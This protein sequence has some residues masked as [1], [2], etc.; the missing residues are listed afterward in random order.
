M[1]DLTILV[2]RVYEW[3][4]H[5][6]RC[7]YDSS[8]RIKSKFGQR[9]STRQIRSHNKQQPV[10]ASCEPFALKRASIIP[11]VHEQQTH[12]T[13]KQTTDTLAH[14]NNP[15]VNKGKRTHLT[16]TNSDCDQDC[17]EWPRLSLVMFFEGPAG[18]RRDGSMDAV[19]KIE[20]FDRI[21]SLPNGPLRGLLGPFG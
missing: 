8:H 20:C 4:K 13:C 16:T 21:S 2:I 1:S 12:A 9:R 3:R 14:S 19:G 5:I 11:H 18:G 17:H 10:T 15:H 7:T 6:I